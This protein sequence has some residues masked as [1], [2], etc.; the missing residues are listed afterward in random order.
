MKLPS[1]DRHWTSLIM[2]TL[3]QV[4][5]LCCQ[6][7]SCY[8]SQCW[9]RSMWPYGVT[10]PQCVNASLSALKATWLGLLLCHSAVSELS[11]W[12][13]GRQDSVKVLLY[14]PSP[15]LPPEVHAEP[16]KSSHKFSIATWAESL[17]APRSTRRA[18]QIIPQIL[19]KWAVIM[20]LSFFIQCLLCLPRSHSPSTASV[21]GQQIEK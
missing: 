3:V 4:M 2:S 17:S 12:H 15:W 10:R 20:L 6:A 14:G 9:L 13:K 19:L 16:N 1:G 8:L 5:G 7:T 18:Q 21:S 11:Y